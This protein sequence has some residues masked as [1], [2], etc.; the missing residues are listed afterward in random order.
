[1]IPGLAAGGKFVEAATNLVAS[2]VSGQATVSFDLP[3]YDGKGVS[4]Y[5]AISNPGSITTIGVSSPITITGLTNGVNYT[6]TVTT[7]N[8]SGISAVSASSNIVT[9]LAPG[10][11]GGGGGGG[12]P[13]PRCPP[14]GTPAT[15]AN[16]VEY[17][18]RSAGPDKG[19]PGTPFGP[20]GPDH[21]PIGFTCE[22]GSPISYKYYCQGCGSGPGFWEGGYFPLLRHGVCGYYPPQP[23]GGSNPV[24]CNFSCGSPNGYTASGSYPA[25]T[26][27]PLHEGHTCPPGCTGLSYRIWSK[28]NCPNTYQCFEGPGSCTGCPQIDSCAGQICAPSG[29]EYSDTCTDSCGN[30]GIITYGLQ[31][32]N[33]PYCFN[34]P[35]ITVSRAMLHRTAPIPSKEARAGR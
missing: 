11:G 34:C 2:A 28:T 20:G 24:D 26:N 14:A 27:H 33:V 13:P 3:G 7:I 22:Q 16:A 25:G 15:D 19:A 17:C 31:Y 9:P 30:S 18:D 5:M 8:P 6:F 12:A 10:G 4:T 1:M 32:S 23:G 35:A 21:D 29:F